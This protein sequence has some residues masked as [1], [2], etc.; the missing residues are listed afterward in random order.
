MD[1]KLPAVPEVVVGGAVDV[2]APLPLASDGVLRW[3]WH[4]RFGDM[5]IEVI[6]EE[7]FVNG[8]RVTHAG[9]RPS[10]QPGA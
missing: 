3:L 2:Q 8:E 9:A 10:V 6:G 5:L 7:V 4:S 1:P